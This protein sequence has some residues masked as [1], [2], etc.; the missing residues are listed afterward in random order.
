MEPKPAQEPSPAEKFRA[1]AQKV[2]SVP[3]EAIQRKEAAYKK[4][5]ESKDGKRRPIG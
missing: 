1:F 4:E 2:I 3:K 5:R